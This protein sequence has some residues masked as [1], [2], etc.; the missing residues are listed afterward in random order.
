MAKSR[1]TNMLKSS[2]KV[3]PSLDNGLKKVG[4][5][6]K[7]AAKSS[8]PIVEKGVS[9]VYGTMATGFNLGVNGVSKVAKGITHGKSSR[10]HKKGGKSYKGR[11][12]CKG[13]K[14]RKRRTTRRKY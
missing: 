1:R 2:M 12:S 9:A 6:A 8:I 13:G 14:S 4:S 11:K 10:R 7:Y 5:T 3:L